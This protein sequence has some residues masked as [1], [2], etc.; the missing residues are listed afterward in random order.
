MTMTR[1]QVTPLRP[2]DEVELTHHDTGA[3]IRGQLYELDPELWPGG[4]V[5]DAPQLGPKAILVV[6][7]QFGDP[8]CPDSR[9][10]RLVD[11]PRS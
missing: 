9:S 4:L 2:G 8:A 3:V 6:R 10:L 1:E 7:D 11:D 5:L